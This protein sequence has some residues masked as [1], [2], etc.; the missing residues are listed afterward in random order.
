MSYDFSALDAQFEKTLEHV[1]YELSLLRTG[2][3]TP[4]LLDSISIEAYGSY[5]KI[6][7]VATVSTPEP[8]LLLVTVWDKSILGNV[9]KAIAS[10]NLNLNPVVDGG[11]I[12][13]VVPA[14]TEDRRRE[15]V[16]VLNNKIEDGRKMLRTVRGDERKRIEQLEKT[17]GISEDDIH[18][19]LE[20]LDE[21][22]KLYM[23][24]LDEMATSK[25]A[26]L[27]K[28]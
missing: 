22:M 18:G 6:Q 8:T 9:E 27:M 12:R 13:I 10:A 15:M 2:R 14:L 16:K 3:A 28:V 24:K 25:E 5:L 4:Q 21:R 11:M 17:D 1:R 23:G 19:Y 7:E 26:E 20:T